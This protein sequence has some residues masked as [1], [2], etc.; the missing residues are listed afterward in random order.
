MTREELTQYFGV[1]LSTIKRN[2]K[3]FGLSTFR[4]IFNESDFDKLYNKGLTDSE[5]S[6]QLNTAVGTISNYRKKLNKSTNFKYNRDLLRNQIQTSSGNIEQI[7]NIL[8]IDSRIVD[9]FLNFNESVFEN[10][11]CSEKEFQVILGSLLGDGSIVLN[12]SKNLGCLRFAHSEAQKEY[13]IWKGE[14]LKNLI[15]YERLFNKIERFDKRTSKTYVSYLGLTKEHSFFKE[16]FNKWYSQKE[17]DGKIKNIKHINKDDFKKIEPLG[18][19]IWFQDDGY[20]TKSGYYIATMCFSYE[21]VCFIKQ[22]FKE[23]WNID[24]IIQKNNEIY[25]PSKHRDKFRNLIEPYI[26]DVCKYKLISPCKTPLNEETPIG[27]ISC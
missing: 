16:M 11:E 17:I 20:K 2:L 9:Y 7:S 23:K 14:L 24:I 13:A 10:W 26:H 25:I 19:A 22:V 4:R 3:K 8:N 12:R 21:D 6:R 5:I 15:Y 1:S 27:T 18:L